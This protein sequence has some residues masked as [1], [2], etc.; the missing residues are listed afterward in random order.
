[1][2]LSSF[3]VQAIIETKNDIFG[4]TSKIYLFGSRVDDTQKGGDIDLFLVTDK[5]DDLF[6]KKINF[7]VALQ[8]KVGEQKIDLIFSKDKSRDIEIEARQKGVILDLNEIKLQKYFRECD[9]HLQRI[10]EAY[11]D[12][13]KFI[14]ISCTSYKHLTK[15]E[16]RSIDQY[17]FRFAKLQD[18]IGDKIFKLIIAKYEENVDKLP[19]LDILNK[20]E[21]IGILSSAKKWIGLRKIRNDISHQYE[22]EEDEISLAIN[23]IIA[24]KEVIKNIYLKIKNSK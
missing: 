10:E 19:F 16:V 24:Q 2:R 1:M 8:E 15:E 7:L 14:P 23:N 18:T 12:I 21:K 3:E 17:L 22:E 9:K 13:K 6:D 20:L 5:K 11:E 4:L